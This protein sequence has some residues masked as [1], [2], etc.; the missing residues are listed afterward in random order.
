MP[1]WRTRRGTGEQTYATRTDAEAALTHIEADVSRGQWEDQILRAIM[2]T[3]V[4][5]ELIRRK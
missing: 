3:V 4:D 2:N 5:D 1:C